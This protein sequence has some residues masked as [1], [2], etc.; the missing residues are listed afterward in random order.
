MKKSLLVCS[1][2]KSGRRVRVQFYNNENLN[3]V[4]KFRLDLQCSRQEGRMGSWVVRDPVSLDFFL[5]SD[6]EM[7]LAQK[8]DGQ[9]TVE[10]IH[11]RWVRQESLDWLLQFINKLQRCGLLL[12]WTSSSGG[13]VI[14]PPLSRS[15]TRT[16]LA[17]L[18]RLLNPLCVRLPLFDPNAM[19]KR[20]SPI[21]DALFSRV[22]FSILC[23]ASA[24][25]MFRVLNQ[26]ILT[27][28]AL[29]PTAW[30][31]S[32]SFDRLFAIYFTF[33]AVKLGHE[34][35]HALACQKWRV[36]CHEVGILFF[37]FTPCFYCDTSDSWKLK[38]PEQRAC[39]AAGGLYFELIFATLAAFTWLSTNAQSYTHTLAFDVMIVCTVGTIAVNANPLLKYDGYYILAD[40]TRAPNLAQQSIS[41]LR[42]RILSFFSTIDFFRLHSASAIGTSTF[43]R[44]C[45]QF[46][47]AL[48]LTYRI[49]ILAALLII[50]WRIFESLGLQLLGLG[51]IF[52]SVVR[53][54]QGFLSE[55]LRVVAVLSNAG[56]VR[57]FRT[58]MCLLVFVG[59]GL[60]AFLL[61]IPQFVQA[62][63]LCDFVDL[64]PIYAKHDGRLLLEATDGDFVTKGE[65]IASIDSHSLRIQLLE[66]EADLTILEEQA[67]QLR[68]R[69]V[70]DPSAAL[71]LAG[72]ILKIEQLKAQLI[73]LHADTSNL[74]I[75]ASRDGILYTAFGSAPNQVLADQR[76]SDLGNVPFLS[77][78]FHGRH[79]DRGTLIGWLPAGR[80]QVK[81]YVSQAQAQLLARG[82]PLLARWDAEPSRKFYGSVKRVFPEPLSS[83]PKVLRGDSQ[84]ESNFS[85]AK[86]FAQAPPIYVVL[87]EL[88]SE[89]PSD[90]QR[91]ALGDCHIR[92]AS[93]S[94]FQRLRRTLH[95]KNL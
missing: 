37:A 92:I 20:F 28:V 48:S 3:M 26:L 16:Y 33:I 24:F 7:Q 8:F 58:S 95:W 93:R 45:L 35:G 94:L 44:L 13:R 30:L 56:R 89:V 43:S 82:M 25:A 51:V 57:R 69:L 29:R 10:C 22:F 12:P 36:E 53:F 31:T 59:L 54:M 27:P 38:R 86:N 87:V 14:A 64:G 46:Y 60:L 63:M 21:A 71:E 2:F 78:E 84:F 61:P 9:H 65:K 18:R 4:P 79:I 83:P 62:R 74:Q 90:M 68:I 47:A 70:D 81:A 67:Q 55:V 6:F 39:I 19:L 11:Q 15:D 91:H 49:T 41:L 77:R 73:L 17:L 42:A 1:S 32:V 85:V 5:F 72:L 88:E 80:L 75:S 66:T 52:V 23:L 76:E 34:I 50:A 40:L